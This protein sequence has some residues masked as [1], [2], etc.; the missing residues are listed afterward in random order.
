MSLE[1][2]E[3]VAYELDLDRQGDEVRRVGEEDQA[4]VLVLHVD[5]KQVELVAVR[6]Q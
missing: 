1:K 5:A 6:E 3:V 2:S 4:D